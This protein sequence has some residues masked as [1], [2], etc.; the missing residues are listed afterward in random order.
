MGQDRGHRRQ[1][2]PAGLIYAGRPEATRWPG[3]KLS[4]NTP[5]DPI[6]GMHLGAAAEFFMFRRTLAAI[7]R[8]VL[9]LG[10]ED[11]PRLYTW[12]KIHLGVNA[13]RAPDPDR[14]AETETAVLDLL[15]P[16][17]NVRGRP[18]SAIRARLAE[19]RHDP[20]THRLQALRASRKAGTLQ[21]H[22]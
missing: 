10:A 6:T 13:V 3:A 19:L 7:L 15:D 20:G 12:I 8:P 1:P 16:P 18:P 4:Q 17:L 14:L 11:D 22:E 21:D 5:R 2:V 9:D